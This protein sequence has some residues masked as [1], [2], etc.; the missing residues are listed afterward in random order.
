MKRILLGAL[1][2]LASFAVPTFAQLKEV[3]DPQMRQQIEAAQ[4]NYDVAFNKHDAAAVA[5]LFTQDTVE[6]GPDGPA[7]GQQAIEKRYSDLF[8]NWQPTPT[9]HLNTVE[10]MYMLGD[11]VYVIQKWS[12][13]GYKGWV[14]LIMAPKG[15]DWLVQRATYNITQPAATPYPTTQASK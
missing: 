8:R 9:D 5:A 13:G 6:T 4:K 15:N 2:G 11:N 12:V 3:D 1:I 14:T 7:Y 10:K